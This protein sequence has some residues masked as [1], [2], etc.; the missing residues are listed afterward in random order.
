MDTRHP[1]ALPA[2]AGPLDADPAGL[3]PAP[4]MPMAFGTRRDFCVAACQALSLGA[5]AA[6]LQACGGGGDGNPNSPN[7]PPLASL[8]ALN[9]TV[10]NG[11]ASLS[12]A[13]T[14][15]ASN[16]GAAI[17]TTPNF[18]QVLVVRQ[19]AATVSV[20]TAT[21]THQQCTI[22][23]F[24]GGTFECPCHGSRFSATGTVVRGPATANLRRFTASIDN[25]VITI[26]A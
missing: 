14:A 1:V 18:G 10:V 3:P 24:E 9:A 11:A 8:P 5:I 17:V 21:C 26:T 2:A 12:V 15:L 16:G 7:G 19:D 4:A 13:G 23:G 20:L 25:G 22:T 6:T